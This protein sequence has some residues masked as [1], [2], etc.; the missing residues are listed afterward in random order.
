VSRVRNLFILVLFDQLL[1]ELNF[2][3]LGGKGLSF[4]HLGIILAQDYDRIWSK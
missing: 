1:P 2:A 4:G 3:D